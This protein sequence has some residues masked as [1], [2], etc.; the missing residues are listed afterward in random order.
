MA[1][2][3]KVSSSKTQIFF[4]S[5][6]AED[7]RCD[8]AMRLGYAQVEDLGMYLGMPLIHRRVTTATY[9]GILEKAESRLAGWKGR[10]LSAAGRLT[11]TRSAL[12]SFPYYAIQAVALPSTICNRLDQ[13]GRTF[14]WGGSTDQRKPHLVPWED[15]CQ[16]LDCGGLGL[17]QSKFMNEALLMNL[18]WHMLT[19]P[20]LLWVRVMCAKY[21]LKPNEMT[22][23]FK[24]PNGSVCLRAV[25]KVWPHVRRGTRWAL[26]NGRRAQF[27][28]DLWANTSEPLITVAIERIPEEFIQ[29]PVAEFVTEIG[30]WWWE[31]FERFLPTNSLLL[32]AAVLPPSPS[33]R[34]DRLVWGYTPNGVF[35]TKTTYEAL[36]RGA[37]DP[38]RPLWRTIWRA[39]A[40]QRVRHFLWLASRDRLFTNMERFCRHMAGGAACGL[41]GQPEST[42]HVLRDCV[43]ARNI[44]EVLIPNSIRKE[45]FVHDAR[46]WIWSNLVV[47]SPD[48]VAN[49]A[50][51]FSITCWRIWTWRNLAVFSNNFV[52]LKVKI[53]DIRR[54]VDR[55]VST[56]TCEAVLGTRDRHFIL[57]MDGSLFKGPT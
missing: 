9:A 44:W 4:S 53:Q 38:S 50:S 36:T 1:S 30:E 57:V 33:A 55:Y 17:K 35:S 32:I 15:I 41:C 20:N 48:G 21:N 40:A 2:G 52:P 42:S 46:A 25:A 24:F 22:G 13:C 11:L 27:W 3:L 7:S 23:D 49:W 16:P 47:Y 54:R 19:K 6:V 29:A 34:P 39:P 14:L 18:E 5:S 26:G 8:I 45:F 12:S 43:H 10:S 56:M 28:L 51:I 31:K 37:T